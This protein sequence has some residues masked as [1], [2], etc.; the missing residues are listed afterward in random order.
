MQ[1]CS[2]G[3]GDHAVSRASDVRL[4]FRPKHH[5]LPLS[6]TSFDILNFLPAL[7]SILLRATTFIPLTLITQI[8]PNQ[9]GHPTP[10]LNIPR[11][12]FPPQIQIPILRTEVLIGLRSKYME[13]AQEKGE[14]GMG[15]TSSGWF[16]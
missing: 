3:S 13:S 12:R 6:R 4:W 5:F 14:E 1:L 15:R 16:G 11:Q 2:I 10:L 7:Y 8:I 9:L